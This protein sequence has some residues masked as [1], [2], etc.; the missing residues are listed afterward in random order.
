MRSALA[1]H[2]IPHI[3]P[4][5]EP[6][7]LW[8][9]GAP[10]LKPDLC[11][12][13]CAMVDAWFSNIPPHCYPYQVDFA[14]PASIGS[15]DTVVDMTHSFPIPGVLHIIHNAGRALE[16]ALETYEEATSRLDKVSKLLTD[17]DGF[18][19][20]SHFCLSSM[21]K[22]RNPHKKGVSK[23]K[24]RGQTE[25]YT[26]REDKTQT[27]SQRSRTKI[28][29]QG[30]ENFLMSDQL[31]TKIDVWAN[32]RCKATA[33]QQRQLA[34]ASSLN[35]FL[36]HLSGIEGEIVC[37]VLPKQLGSIAVAS[38]KCIHWKMLSRKVGHCLLMPSAID[39]RA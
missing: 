2:M 31:K 37:N 22:P 20:W 29:L 27:E 6:P 14:T 17:K 23:Q 11:L 1:L 26:A 19:F 21:I 32:G 35:H 38:H 3:N 7:M 39:A 15:A 24:M 5:A 28:F 8:R 25:V 12:G 10:W 13:G 18:C 4:S 16:G 34:T 30:R 33:C 36:P 9:G